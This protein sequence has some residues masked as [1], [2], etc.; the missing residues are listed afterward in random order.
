MSLYTLAVCHTVNNRPSSRLCLKPRR[1]ST[2]N[3]SL[4]VSQKTFFRPVQCDEKLSAV[5]L[6]PTDC[7]NN[8]LANFSLT[9]HAF[10]RRFQSPC[11]LP[12]GLREVWMASWA[13]LDSR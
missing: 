13:F 11:V 10:K 9:W 5:N 4:H 3:A 2:W 12:V 6:L 8:I 7:H 1:G